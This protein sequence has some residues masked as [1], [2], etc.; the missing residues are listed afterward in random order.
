MLIS[1]GAVYRSD[2]SASKAIYGDGDLYHDNDHCYAMP[3]WSLQ[4]YN[5]SAIFEL[6]RKY[7][8]RPGRPL[9]QEQRRIRDLKRSDG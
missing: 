4:Q 3:V 6:N 1:R 5:E 7:A 2:K 9:V 8:G